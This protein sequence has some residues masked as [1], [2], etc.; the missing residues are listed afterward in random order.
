LVIP[1]SFAMTLILILFVVWIGL[2]LLMGVLAIFLQGYLNETPPDIREVAMHSPIAGTILAVFLGIWCFLGTRN[3]PR[4]AP[5]TEF[6]TREDQPYFKE[7]KAVVYRKDRNVVIARDSDTFHLRH[8]DAGKEEYKNTRGLRMPPRPDELIVIEDGA[9]VKF[10]PDRDARGEFKYEKGQGLRYV[11]STGRVMRE[12]YLGVVTI[13]RTGWF[14]T[15]LLINLFH[16]AFWFVAFWPIMRFTLGQSIAISVVAW[17]TTTLFVL[18]P[19]LRQAQAIYERR[20]QEAKQQTSLKKENRR[21]SLA[22]LP[23]VSRVN[24]VGPDGW[25][26]QPGRF[27]YLAA[28]AAGNSIL[29]FTSWPAVTATRSVRISPLISAFRV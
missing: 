17:I 4:W 1:P 11:D 19:L 18:P 9:E 5:L 6:S 14:I 3:P 7:M 27:N 24:S 16:G 28:T 15:Y 2:C 22:T 10:L 20:Q 26:D 12:G 13:T 21:E 29:T 8:D 23:P 25:T